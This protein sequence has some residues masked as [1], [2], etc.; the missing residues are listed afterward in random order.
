MVGDF[1]FTLSNQIEALF[2]YPAHARKLT[3]EVTVSK[4]KMAIDYRCYCFMP[5]KKDEHH[6][7]EENNL[8]TVL[9]LESFQVTW[10]IDYLASQSKR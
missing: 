8:W 2:E 3:A 9:M 1:D 4:K 10:C 7:L 6:W 5:L